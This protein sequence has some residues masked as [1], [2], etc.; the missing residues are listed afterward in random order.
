MED[1]VF[2]L[3]MPQGIQELATRHAKACGMTRNGY[4]VNCVV[5]AMQ[6]DGVDIPEEWL[7]E[8]RAAKFSQVGQ[9][10]KNEAGGQR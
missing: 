6:A 5:Q 7:P 1:K 3:R 9:Q 8:A 10:K 4:I 2:S